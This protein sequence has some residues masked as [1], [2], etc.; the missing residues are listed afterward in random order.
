MEQFIQ[1]L[2]RTFLKALIHASLKIDFKK[3]FY[4]RHIL[5]VPAAIRVRW[6]SS[7]QLSHGQQIL[8]IMQTNRAHNIYYSLID[9]R[10]STRA[11]VPATPYIKEEHCR[12]GTSNAKINT[13]HPIIID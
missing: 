3:G 7:F 6:S 9:V 13:Q 11:R 8:S 10:Q 4:L 1:F 12:R 5:P 2:L